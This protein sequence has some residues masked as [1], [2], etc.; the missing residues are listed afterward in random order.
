MNRNDDMSHTF[1]VTRS[2]ALDRLRKGF[3]L[4]TT[5][6]SL[7]AKF[8]ASLPGDIAVSECEVWAGPGTSL[9]Y[10]FHRADAKNFCPTCHRAT[11]L[12]GEEFVISDL[13]GIYDNAHFHPRCLQFEQIQLAHLE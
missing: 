5:V 11:G 9:W 13:S 7:A 6:S 2:D 3:M 10:A 12:G 8:R 1:D 4:A